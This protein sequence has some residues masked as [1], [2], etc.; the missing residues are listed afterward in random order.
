M[1]SSANRFAI[2]L[3]SLKLNCSLK[4]ALMPDDIFEPLRFHFFHVLHSFYIYFTNDNN[5]ILGC[6]AT[7]EMSVF[8]S[9]PTQASSLTLETSLLIWDDQSKILTKCAF[10][11]Q[12]FCFPFPV[13]RLGRIS[14]HYQYI[15]NRLS[16]QTFENVEQLLAYNRETDT[17]FA[18]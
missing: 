9:V 13:I 14:N 18:I 16:Q 5:L 15:T 12:F 7:T 8:G 2:F 11:F 1:I 10:E 4:A 17:L 3:G 6:T